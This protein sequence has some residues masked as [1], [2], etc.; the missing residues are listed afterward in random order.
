MSFSDTANAKKY[1]SIAEVAAAQAKLYAS[2][3]EGAPDYA[4]QAAASA[5]ASAA[6]AQAA[7]S[8][9]GVV[10][11]LVVSASEYAT[12]AAASAADA[13]NAAAAAVGQCL[14]VPDGESVDVLPVQTERQDSFLTFDASGNAALLPKEDVAILDAEGK[15]PVSMIPAV[16]LSEIFV[17]SSQAAMLALDVQIGD[18]AKRTDIGF[19]FALA[20]EPASTLS[21]WVQLNDD[22]MAQLALTSGASNIGALDDS[23]GAS[24]VQTLLNAKANKTTLAAS[25]G[26]TTVGALDS[27]LSPS[28]VQEVLDQKA[29][30]SFG[31]TTL[32]ASLIRSF[33]YFG[34]KGDGTTDDTAAIQAAAVWVTGGN[35]RYLTTEQGKVAYRVTSTINFNFANGRGHA[36]LMKSPIRP[37]AG[38]GTAFLIQ[39]TRNSVFDLKVDGGGGPLVDYTQPDPSGAQ[40]AFYIRGVREC[41]ININGVSYSGRVL[42]TNGL[43]ASSGG[44]IKM[45]FNTLSINTGDR[46]G[47]ALSGRC[48]QGYYLQGDSSAWGKIQTAWIQWDSYGSVHDGLTD[49]TVDN[50]EFGSD[51]A[52]GLKFLGIRT[53]HINT[54]S[55]GDET[56]TNTVLYFGPTT[57][58]QYCAGVHINRIF[59]TYGVVGVEFNGNPTSTTVGEFFVESIT[60]TD[61]TNCGIRVNNCSSSYFGLYSVGDSVGIKLAGTCR[62][63]R[64]RNVHIQ[65]SSSAILAESGANIGNIYVEGRIIGNSGIANVD[66]TNAASVGK[67]DFDKVMCLAPNSAY[68]IPISNVVSVRNGAIDLAGTGTAFPIGPAKVVMNNDGFITRNRAVGMIGAGNQTVTISH[69]L[70]QQPTEICITPTSTVT[71]Y[72]VTNITATSFNVR[73]STALGASDPA[74]TFNWTASCEY[75]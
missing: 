19:S 72:A 41:V 65:S 42:R 20:S 40:T 53:G 30:S 16:A 66:F 74:W 63:V 3:L 28:T 36:I 5:T 12:E 60:T 44:I 2:K 1:A 47:A 54:I 8:A 35:N 4:A 51:Q 56:T 15:V 61:N 58:G 11:N 27:S 9:E 45:S 14:R 17:V 34:A 49:F 62:N 21:N 10:N 43:D 33:E 25:S 23:S 48:G 37:D 13:G 68:K 69:G 55:G 31:Q 7:V 57:G 26:A 18:I 52:G 71:G 75:H 39:N 64:F 6:S 32:S 38:T 70:A 24:T 46:S 67:I 59:S 50:I 73:L 22:V 29:N